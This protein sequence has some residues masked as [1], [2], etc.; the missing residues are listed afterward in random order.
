MIIML[1][2][3]AAPVQA[4]EGDKICTVAFGDSIAFGYSGDGEEIINYPS[5]LAQE[6]E[7]ET[8]LP[9][10]HVNYAKNGLTTTKLNSTILNNE[11][12]LAKIPHADI[13]TLTIGAN[14]LMNE[15]KKAAQE[16]L[17]LDRK[18]QSADDAIQALQEGISDNPLI[19]VKIIN[20]ISNW[21][22]ESFELQWT[23]AM[24]TLEEEKK[25][26]AQVIVTNIYNP[27]SKMELPGT[28]N[29][30]I[31]KIISKM[32][33]IMA[34]HEQT[35][36]YQV[37]D[38]FREDMGAYTQSDGLHPNQEGQNLIAEK[39]LEQTDMTVFLAEPET[40]AGES[41]TEAAKPEKK[42]E[43]ASAKQEK[44]PGERKAVLVIM[45]A[46]IAALSCVLLL[47]LWESCQKKKNQA[48]PEKQD[49]TP[50]ADP[51]KSLIQ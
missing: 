41:D 43:A 37:V 18:F 16:I 26:E 47:S 27:V 1:G 32:N 14:D 10:E 31:E 9:A 2:V 33:D 49:K 19:I 40:V 36:G 11:E 38:L 3:S 25:E 48:S 42:K 12:V 50:D 15:F 44:K 24:N 23:E 28:L 45:G 46:N 13:I 6:L 7:R 30:V 21:D 39:M 22:Y 5:L 29:S 8:A 35:Y 20:V 34:K 17:N 4:W 51:K